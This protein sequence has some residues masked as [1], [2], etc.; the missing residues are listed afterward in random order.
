MMITDLKKNVAFVVMALA[1]TTLGFVI[2]KSLFHPSCEEILLK[3]KKAEIA[4]IFYLT[5]SRC[6]K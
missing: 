5:P 4:N 2:L 3:A 1:L 6:D